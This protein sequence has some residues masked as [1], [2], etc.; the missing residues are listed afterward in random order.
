MMVL[1]RTIGKLQRD[2]PGSEHRQVRPEGFLDMQ[3]SGAWMARY[4]YS[5]VPPWGSDRFEEYN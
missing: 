1:A 4:V 2:L 5:G 3:I